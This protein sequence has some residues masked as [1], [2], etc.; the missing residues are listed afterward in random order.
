MQFV[1]ID[2]ELEV[3]ALTY[4]LRSGYVVERVMAWW[5]AV[6]GGMNLRLEDKQK[7]HRL[8]SDAV[9][10]RR[11]SVVFEMHTQLKS[12]ADCSS[13]KFVTTAVPAGRRFTDA[14]DC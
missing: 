12:H 3:F 9:V 4:V 13:V 7:P 1:D 5:P 6:E 10:C 8:L 2:L 11:F 14:H